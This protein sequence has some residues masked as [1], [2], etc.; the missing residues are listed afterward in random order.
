MRGI[1]YIILQFKI[2]TLNSPSC[3]QAYISVD[4]IRESIPG[5]Y[6]ARML[7][8]VPSSK[9]A[10]VSSCI[11]SFLPPLLH[12]RFLY[13]YDILLFMFV[14]ITQDRNA[15]N[16]LWEAYHYILLPRFAQQVL[17]LWNSLQYKNVI[18]YKFLYWLS[19]I[20]HEWK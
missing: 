19:I 12:Q 16:A 15:Y 13:K 18:I 5:Q 4:V 8:L 2:L 14:H 11:F 17:P 9:N 7:L 20:P 3:Q 6:K 10:I 1:F